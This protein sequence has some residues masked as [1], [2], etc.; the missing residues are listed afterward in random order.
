LAQLPMMKSL[1]RL[2][3]YLRPHRAR[4]FQ[5]G[6]A[7]TATAAINGSVSYLLKLLVDNFSSIKTQGQLLLMVS[8]IPAVFLLK[9][10]VQYTQAYLMSFISQKIVQ[11]IRDD[12]F[13]H[14]HELSVEFFW[15]RRSAEIMTRVTNDLTNIQSALQFIPLYSVRDT[16]T[17]FVSIGV[18][19]Y[20]NWRFT[21]V[22]L[23]AGPMAGAVLGVLG[24]K[25]RSAAR[26][27]QTITGHIYHRFSES[28]EGMAIVKAF[29][30][31]QGA[32]KK[33][34]EENDAL[35]DQMMRYLRA[36][37]LSGP[38]M[39]F[40]GSLVIALLV[41]F[42]GHEI[43]SGRMTVGDFSAFLV[44]FFMAYGPLKNLAQANSSFQLGIVSWNRVL[45][46]L[47]EKPQVVEP[48][49]P[50]PVPE[51]KGSILFDS[52]T[53]SYP[54]AARPALK[55]IHLEIRPGTAVAFVGASGSGKTTLINLLL[56]M[57]DPA[58]GKILY[59]GLN[60]RDVSLRQL[61]SHIGLVSQ[62]TILFDDTV[63]ANI[64]LGGQNISEAE[65]IEAAKAADAH[66]FIIHMPQGYQTMLGERGVKLSGG[67]RQRL[68]IA[69]AILKKPSVLLLDEATSNLDTASEKAV[70][71]ALERIMKGRTVIM[72]AHRLSTISGADRICVLH[73]GE[74]AEIGPHAELIAKNGIYKRLCE[75]QGMGSAQ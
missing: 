44:A 46:L 1:K 30:Y 6:A 75:I 41:Y 16:L 63:L 15:R 14:L 12:L 21:L 74:I 33:F 35:F 13:R 66:D 37:A 3:P 8:A 48:L 18:L 53:Y 25:M 5:A 71:A 32:I 45:Q 40:L 22:A 36:T 58:L 17:V 70:Q 38:L 73:H 47:D 28:L 27:G 4:L 49:S 64:A 52:V 54:G 50:T 68:A 61:R 43:L 62:T 69:R 65:I 67:Q 7:M 31:E 26:Q 24:R 34:R 51:L 56:R 57:Y 2:M 10:A 59:D 42:G 20:I 39:E 29:N 19:F 55:N 9:L 60:L 23:L 72:V 11:Q